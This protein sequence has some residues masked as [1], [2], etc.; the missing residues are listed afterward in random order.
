MVNSQ[1]YP[2]VYL[3]CSWRKWLATWNTPSSTLEKRM[4]VMNHLKYPVLYLCG[5]GEDDQLSE[6]PCALPLWSRWGWSTVWNTLCSTFV[7]QKKMIN[8]LKYLVLYLCGVGEDDQLSEIPCALPLWSRWGWS[9][10]WNTLCSTF[11]EQKKM[12]NCLKYLV[13]YLC[14]V[15]EDDQLSEIPC[16]LPLWSR[17]GWSTVWNTLCSTFVE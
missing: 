10:V 7:E 14:G 12:I 11:V 15:G 3:F 8:C 4:K 2:P 17:W 9:T 6:I 1:N 5:A 16:A 13:L